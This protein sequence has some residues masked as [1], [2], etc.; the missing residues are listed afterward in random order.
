MGFDAWFFARLDF[1]DKEK[2]DID[3]GMEFVW[4]PFISHLNTTTQIY[5]YAMQDNYCYFD[6]FQWDD[7]FYDDSPVVNDVKLETFNADWKSELLI[8]K[9]LD[10]LEIFQGDHILINQGCDF[11][12]AN[13]R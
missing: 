10:Y 7:R 6:G 11:T 8:D 3:R 4:Q 2:R 12:F 13:A 9:V 1:E 5:T